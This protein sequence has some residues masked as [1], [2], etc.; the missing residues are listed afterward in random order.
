MTDCLLLLIAMTVKVTN[1][2][3]KQSDTRKAP[4]SLKDLKKQLE[5]IDVDFLGYDGNKGIKR[6]I[7]SHYVSADVKKQLLAELEAVDSSEK[8]NTLTKIAYVF[9]EE[10]KLHR[11]AVELLQNAH[12]KAGL[13]NRAIIEAR[14]EQVSPNQAATTGFQNFV[15]P[16]TNDSDS[17]EL[18]GRMLAEFRSQ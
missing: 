5:A 13:Q 14:L 6:E 4:I 15:N 2:V 8:I 1:V 10:S 7:R 18:I 12:S 17:S 16:R 11:K 9:S 3:P